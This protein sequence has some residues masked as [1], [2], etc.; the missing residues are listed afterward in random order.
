M[1]H[2]WPIK[3]IDPGDVGTRDQVPVRIDGDLDRAMAH[4]LLHVRQRRAVLDE[5]AAKRV[6][7][8]VKTE[9]PKTSL[10]Q[11]RLHVTYR[12]VVWF[13][14]RPCFGR[15]DEII[16]YADAAVSLCFGQALLVETEQHAAE[17]P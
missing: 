16:C 14:R 17:L 11:R 6:T 13:L 5:Q 7:Q 1:R 3:P 2:F 12:D 15:E 4:L 9:L 8:V 10:R